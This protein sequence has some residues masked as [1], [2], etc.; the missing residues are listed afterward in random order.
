M[1]IPYYQ[2]DAFTDR[3][4]SGNPAGV[5]MLSSWRPDAML[6]KI[7]LENNL[8]ETAFV[9]RKGDEFELRWMTPSVEVDLCGHAT[10]APAFVIFSELG[11]AAP[12]IRFHTKSGILGARRDGTRITLDFPA[13]KAA[14]RPRGTDRASTASRSGN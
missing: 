11:H 7:A 13:M 5:C 10:L 1:T 12:E 14:S 2:V 4:F 9:V 8:S 3:L 6:Q